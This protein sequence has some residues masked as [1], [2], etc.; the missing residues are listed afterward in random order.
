MND[1]YSNTSQNALKDKFG[2]LFPYLRLSITD[3]CNFRCSYC[4]PNGYIKCNN[5]PR[6]L[7]QNEIANLVDAFASLGVTKIRITGGEPTV[8]KDFTQIAK[9][10]SDHPGI[11]KTSF[12]TNGYLLK[13]KAKCWHDAG[14]T[15]VNVS[16]DSLNEKIFH[17]VSGR[18]LLHKVQQGVESAIKV[19]FQQ[20]KIN[21]VLLKGV[22]GN[23]LK[24]FLPWVKNTN[25]SIR[26]IELMQTGDNLKY[27]QKYHIS[28][29][30]ITDQLSIEGWKNKP[31]ALDSGPAQE[32]VHEDY[33][34]S[35][36]IIAP[37][38]KDFCKGCNRLR[39]TS[40]GDLRLCLFGNQGT[41]LRHLLQTSEQKSL[42]RKLIIEQ[43]NYKSSSHFL[44]Y[45]NTGLTKHLASIGG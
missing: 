18:N 16:I 2:R 22:N 17:A 5:K 3:V 37:Y 32:Y 33:K 20:V 12:T 15:H 6:F 38:S 29:K 13:D 1:T 9:L 11:E 10:I 39:V 42:L 19:G 31:R 36:G 44:A 43:L 40:I 28:T 24:D 7:S 45:G 25:I 30:I 41:S 8:R 14:L 4:L 35:I 26:F 27:F 34:G 21:V 23:A